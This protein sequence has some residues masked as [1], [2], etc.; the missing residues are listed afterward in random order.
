MNFQTTGY[1]IKQVQQ[2]IHTVMEDALRPV[3][4]NLSQYNVLKNLEASPF[5]TGAELARKAFVTPQT[6]HTMLTTM[7]RK[8]LIARSTIPGNKKSFHVSIAP[9]GK[10]ALAGAEQALQKLFDSANRALTPQEHAILDILL[11]KLSR[12]L[13]ESNL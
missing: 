11:M 6:T 7:E 10:K 13:D 1:T 2:Q 9:G 4:L 3:S 8:G 12:E 5:V